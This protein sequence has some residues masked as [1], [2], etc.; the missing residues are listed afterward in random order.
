MK[1]LGHLELCGSGN[2][3]CGILGC[4][5]LEEP[6]FAKHALWQCLGHYDRQDGKAFINRYCHL[7]LKLTEE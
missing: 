3:D 6:Y 5:L 7:P 4:V 1:V 2:E